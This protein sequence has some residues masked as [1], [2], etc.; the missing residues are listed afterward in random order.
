MPSKRSTPV[1]PRLADE[2]FEPTAKQLDTF[3]AAIRA[4]VS[5]VQ[6]SLAHPPAEPARRARRPA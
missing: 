4:Q 1:D 3:F 6:A 2:R 5:V